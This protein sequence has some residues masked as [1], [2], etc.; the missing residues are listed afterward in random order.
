MDPQPP[1]TASAPDDVTVPAPRP[2]FRTVGL[3]AGVL[4]LAYLTAMQT[5]EGLGW[6][7]AGFGS[8]L[9]GA[10]GALVLHAWMGD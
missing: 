7:A 9:V 5:G 1:T 10:W 6:W 2:P 3:M 8:G 4:F